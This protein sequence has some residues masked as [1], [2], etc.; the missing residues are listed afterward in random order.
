LVL[1]TELA[2]IGGPDLP[3]DV[4]AIDSFHAVTDAP[5]RGLTIV[6]RIEVALDRIFMAQEQLCDVLDRCHAVS[7][8][9]LDRAPAWL[10]EV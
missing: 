8:Y 7:T 4:S 6:S 10:D 1:A 2:G 9:L 5:E 3:L